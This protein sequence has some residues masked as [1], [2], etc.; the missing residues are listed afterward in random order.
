MQLYAGY[1]VFY[2]GH[3]VAPATARVRQS[4]SP[5]SSSDYDDLM[6]GVD[7][8]QAGLRRCENLFVTGGSGG[9]VL[10]A[11]IIGKTNRFRAA[12]VKPVISS[13]ASCVSRLRLPCSRCRI[14]SRLKPPVYLMFANEL[15][16]LTRKTLISI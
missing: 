15:W 7:A 8:I 2:A 5:L 13:A 9:G 4:H 6:S 14:T 16:A 10:S 12:V 3:A 11:W 1:V